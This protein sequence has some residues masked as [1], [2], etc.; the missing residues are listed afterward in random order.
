MSE[1]WSRDIGYRKENYLGKLSNMHVEK[2]WAETLK[3]ELV[4]EKQIAGQKRKLLICI[5]VNK[6]NWLARIFYDGIALLGKE[7]EE[8][9]QLRHGNGMKG[10]YAI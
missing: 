2:K 3:N 7:E 9:C 4:L 5:T 1:A 8:G 6:G 10:T